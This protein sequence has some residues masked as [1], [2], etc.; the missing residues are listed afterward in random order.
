MLPPKSREHR[1]RVLEQQEKA[2]ADPGAITRQHRLDP[3]TK[4]PL[5]VEV[6]GRA[7]TKQ[8]ARRSRSKPQAD[9]PEFGD[10]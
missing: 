9:Q 5:I 4:M 7:G 10:F 8:R 2:A 6:K 3:Q 1:I